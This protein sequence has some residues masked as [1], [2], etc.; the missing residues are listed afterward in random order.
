MTSDYVIFA[1]FVPLTTV[2][3]A[4]T[5]LHGIYITSG[6]QIKVVNVPTYTLSLTQNSVYWITTIPA[7]TYV[8]RVSA[9]GYYNLDVPTTI[10]A[11]KQITL[12][13]KL[14]PIVYLSGRPI[15]VTVARLE[16]Y[17]MLQSKTMIFY[18]TVPWS[19]E[20]TSPYFIDPQG[21]IYVEPCFNK[22]ATIKITVHYG[23]LY[24]PV[25]EIEAH[26]VAYVKFNITE[27]YQAYA[28]ESYKQKLDTNHWTGFC[29]QSDRH[30]L[31]EVTGFPYKPLQV[32]HCDTNGEATEI[33]NWNWINDESAILL[34][35]FSTVSLTF[36]EAPNTMALWVP[37]L[38]SV[39]MVAIALALIKRYVEI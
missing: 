26:N 7:G 32:F 13:V 33:K 34:D 16:R 17:M 10:P 29:V 25:V 38:T 12:F 36:G 1:T 4:I 2:I 23:T 27:L 30:L 18:A 8:F 14:K 20:Y 22:T 3:F 24:F 15:E 11:Q 39:M 6:V 35:H 21:L 37:V 5:D 28:Q 19:G 9:P 31:L